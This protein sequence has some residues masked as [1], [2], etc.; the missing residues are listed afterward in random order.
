VLVRALEPV[1]GLARMRRHRGPGIPDRGL[2][3]G[4]GKLCQALAITLAH[5]GIDA[6][7]ERL[8]I[9]DRGC[10]VAGIEQSPRIGVDYAGV[11]AG[12]PWRFV[13]QCSANIHCH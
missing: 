7:G 1:Q 8:W 11:W 10:E 5:N 4:P 9:E 12:K 6:C 2:A 13:E 3:D